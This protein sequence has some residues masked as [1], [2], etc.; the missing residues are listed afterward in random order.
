VVGARLRMAKVKQSIGSSLFDVA[1]I[2]ILTLLSVAFIY[3]LYN[4]LVI[5]FS[6]STAMLRTTGILLLPAGFS[7][8]SY[9]FLFSDPLLLRYYLNTVY[10]AGTGTFLMLLVT[11]L[12]AYPMVYRQ[13]VGKK[14]ITVIMVITMF[15]GGGLIPY[16]ILIKQLRMAD[17]LWVMIVPNA[18][19]A[20]NMILFRTFF[21]EIPPSLRESAMI[22]GASHFRI[23]FTIILPL[24]KPLLATF[25]L[26]SLVGQWNDFFTALL[27]L[28]DRREWPVQMML[29]KLLVL[30]DFT[31]IQNRVMGF[32][33]WSKYVSS[34]TLKCAAVIVT[35]APILCVYPFMQKYFVKGV[36][37]GSIKG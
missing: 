32:E 15:F 25:A 37:V 23:L 31:D 1:N 35:V 8:K 28:N 24:S 12:M 6:E 18:I 4:T 2:T 34:R 16:Y 11:S 14:L 26:F 7:L 19:S 21:Q 33:L 10:Y 17:T 27:F 5:S 13:F 9:Q 20:W 36:L 3:P 22:D 29:R 30:V